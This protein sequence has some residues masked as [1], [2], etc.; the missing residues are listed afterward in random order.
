MKKSSPLD[1]IHTSLHFCQCLNNI[2]KRGKMALPNV[3]SNV[4][5]IVNTS[6]F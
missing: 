1:V 3:F 2:Y 5:D 6:I 4:S